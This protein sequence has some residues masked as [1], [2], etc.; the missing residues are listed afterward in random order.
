MDDGDGDG[1]G[2]KDSS[3]KRQSTWEYIC[4]RFRGDVHDEDGNVVC[5]QQKTPYIDGEEK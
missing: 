3:K 1:D 4:V 5:V 2:V